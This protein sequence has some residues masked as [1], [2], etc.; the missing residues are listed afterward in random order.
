[1]GV[2]IETLKDGDNATFPQK[3]QKVGR[4]KY[5]E[6]SQVMVRSLI[7]VVLRSPV[8]MSSPWR[9]GRRLTAP[10][11]AGVPS[12]SLSARRRLLKAGSRA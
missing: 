3:G 8:T 9:A 12:C 5:S 7:T 10:E 1:M 11:T 2:Q 6:D 4:E